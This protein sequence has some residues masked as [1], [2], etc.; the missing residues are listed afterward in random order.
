MFILHRTNTTYYCGI[1]DVWHIVLRNSQMPRILWKWKACRMS[2]YDSSIVCIVG[3]CQRM[4][5][6]VYLASVSLPKYKN[7]HSLSCL[8]YSQMK[9]EFPIIFLHSVSLHMEYVQMKFE[10][11]GLL[12]CEGSFRLHCRCDAVN[13][14]NVLLFRSWDTH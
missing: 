1:L 5:G 4:K 6:A 7:Q 8:A 14:C 10:F 12:T 9:A 13:S 3:E 2:K 11:Q